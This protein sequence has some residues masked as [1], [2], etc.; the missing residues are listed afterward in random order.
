MDPVV[1]QPRCVCAALGQP[2]KGPCA[3]G[4]N[5]QAPSTGVERG[6][7][8]FQ[9]PISGQCKTEP[10]HREVHADVTRSRSPLT[11]GVGDYGAR[12]A[13]EG[14]ARVVVRPLLRKGCV[15]LQN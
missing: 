7:N 15:K 3:R 1:R 13:A 6:R 11:A 2:G 9:S 8:R 4:T 5:A 14:R 10:N 12:R